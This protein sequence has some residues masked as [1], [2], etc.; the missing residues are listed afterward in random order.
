[1]LSS[2]LMTSPDTISYQIGDLVVI[3]NPVE[4]NVH[5]NGKLATITSRPE[6]ID[7][8]NGEQVAVY[9]IQ[10]VKS[11][12]T[13]R[14]KNG[15]VY[16]TEVTSAPASDRYDDNKLFGDIIAKREDAPVTLYAV[17][18]GHTGEVVIRTKPRD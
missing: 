6:V 8:N 16:S 4:A 12:T 14:Y 15:I 7:L 2:A 5:F 11:D 10:I 17:E 3:T 9:A 1:M 18:V 13:H